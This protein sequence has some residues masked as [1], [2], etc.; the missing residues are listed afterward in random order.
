M[1][2]EHPIELDLPHQG[3]RLVAPIATTMDFIR[4]SAPLVATFIGMAVAEW[5]KLSSQISHALASKR[6]N[7]TAIRER[8][9]PREYKL[10]SKN[11]DDLPVPL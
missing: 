6:R 9:V 1:L 5:R 8:S 10:T 4:C 3:S 7:R 11:D 2:V